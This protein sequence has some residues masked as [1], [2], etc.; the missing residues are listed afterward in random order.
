MLTHALTPND[1]SEPAEQELPNKGTDWG[2]DLD[3][4]ILVGVQGM[5]FTINKAQH[6]RGDV[7]GEEIISS[8]Q[9]ELNRW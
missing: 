3:A 9:V 7:D 8:D 4:K 6:L 2:G 5:A 1:V